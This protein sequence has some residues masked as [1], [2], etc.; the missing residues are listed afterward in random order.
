MYK[1]NE[2]LLKKY[3][4]VLVKFALNSGKGINTGDVVQLVVPDVAKPL[5]LALYQSVLEAGGHPMV[6]LLPSG[7]DRVFYDHAKEFQ[8]TFFPKEYIKSRIQTIDHSVGILAEHDLHELS[9]VDP[10]RII[11]TQES[12]KKAREWM[13]DKEYAGNFTWTLALFGTSAMAAEA[14]LTLEAYWQEI[15]H[16]CFL[17]YDDPI[18]EWKRVAS[19][20]ARIKRALKALPINRLH[21]ES[22]GTDLWLT[23]GE[24]RKWVG[25]GGRNIP[26][27]EIFTS[28]DWRGTTGVI[29][30]NQPLY[31]YGQL[32]KDV[33]LEFQKGKVVKSTASKN[34]ALLLQMID[35]P[36]A[37]KVGEFSL[38]DARMS[39]ITKFMANTLFDE[40]IGN[41][42]GNTHIAVGMSY[43][44]AYDGDPRGIKKEEWKRLGFNDSGEH[45]DIVST[46][47]RVVTA[48]MHDGSFRVIFAKGIFQ[49]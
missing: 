36:N 2:L 38:T 40:N 29:S 13:S 15:I 45:C 27:F 5:L 3:A 12:Q 1:P 10:S 14:G 16:A 32:I 20:Q 44:D 28:P 25:G 7:L 22:K 41:R 30:F 48:E 21:I 11:K 34:Q 23:L 6:R 26:S 8:L 33:R 35:R 39:R 37:D 49:V 4:D 17:D 19:E 31:R 43:K 18:S 46:D 9:G 47:D 42:Y 24:K